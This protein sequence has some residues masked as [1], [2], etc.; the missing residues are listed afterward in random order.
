[1]APTYRPNFLLASLTADAM[2]LDSVGSSKALNFYVDQP[3]QI[4]EKFSPTTYAKGE[5]HLIAISQDFFI[6]RFLF[7]SN[8]YALRCSFCEGAAVLHMLRQFL[9][10]KTFRGG[11]VR[12]FR[13]QYRITSIISFTNRIPRLSRADITQ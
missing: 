10:E 9:G 3:Q 5:F 11:L 6:H 8:D 7:Q 12:Y 1:V 2:K 4:L 13:Q